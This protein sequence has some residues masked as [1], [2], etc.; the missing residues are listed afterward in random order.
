MEHILFSIIY[1]IIL[2][3]DFYYFSRWLNQPVG[4]GLIQ[5]GH[6]E[7]TH[8][9][10][11]YIIYIFTY[12]YTHIIYIYTYTH[13]IYIHILHIAHIYIYTCQAH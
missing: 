9:D 1:G 2:P 4:H 10:V 3:I 6:G 7:H 5:T 11:Y 8:R 13:I 12:T